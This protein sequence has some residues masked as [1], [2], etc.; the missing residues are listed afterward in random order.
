M[1]ARPVDRCQRPWNKGLLVGQNKLFSPSRT[2]VYQVSVCKS[3]GQCV[4]LRSLTSQS[5]VNFAPVTGS[6]C[7]WTTF[8]QEQMCSVSGTIV[9]TGDM[10]TSSVRD[11]GAAQGIP[12]QPWLPTLRA[13]K[14]DRLPNSCQSSHF[15]SPICP[16][17]ASLG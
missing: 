3:R 7:D 2:M 4:T 16:A 10:S 15:N 1:P 5:T 13:K 14:R 17:G 6:N 9:Q 8:A 11:L 12:S